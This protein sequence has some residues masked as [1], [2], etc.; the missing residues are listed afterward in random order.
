MNLLLMSRRLNWE[1]VPMFRRLNWKCL[2][3]TRDFLA[4]DPYVQLQDSDD[5]YM[6]WSIT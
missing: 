5:L 4:P 3:E 6:T 2:C 1:T